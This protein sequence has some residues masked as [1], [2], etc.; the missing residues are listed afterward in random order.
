MS[1]AAPPHSTSMIIG[2]PRQRRMLRDRLF[3]ALCVLITLISVIVLAVLLISIVKQGLT[4]LNWEFL[5]NYPSRIPAKAGFK[6]AMWG[7]LWL[8]AICGLVALPLGIGAAVYLE[9]FAPRNKFTT[10]IKLNISNL[11]GV[12]SIVYGIIGLTAFTYMFGLFGSPTDPAVELGDPESFFYIR[13]PFGGCVLTGGLTL[14]IVVLPIVIIASQEAIRAVPD[15]L[16]EGA[17][18]TG[19]TRWQMV[20]RMTLP[21]ALPGIMTG[22]ILAI[23]RA[24]GEAAPLLVV[25]GFLFVTFTP[26]NLM[27]DFAAM[28]LQIYNWASRP[29]AEFAKVAA[30]GII[31]LLIIL[32][33][34]NAIAVFIR[35]KFHKPLQ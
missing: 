3:V 34:F 25:G 27:D 17:L 2:V 24:I 28:P 30:S 8:V 14:M 1:A 12:P 15:S 19:A 5:K 35:Q 11:A 32:L 7:S 18:A 9:E 29:Q 33:T 31:V 16:R 22:V 23:S 26:R 20:S 6:G 21:A 10:F 13:L 4:Y